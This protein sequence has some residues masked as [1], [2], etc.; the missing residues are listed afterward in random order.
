MKHQK[1]KV[2]KDGG[3]FKYGISVIDAGAN[4]AYALDEALKAEGIEQEG[5]QLEDFYGSFELL[6]LC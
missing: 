2:L 1:S 6:K 3:N 4:S 5:Y